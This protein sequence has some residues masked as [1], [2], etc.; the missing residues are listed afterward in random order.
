MHFSAEI[1]NGI[2]EYGGAGGGRTTAGC[3]I[4]WH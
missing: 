4:L 2:N 3:I 1:I